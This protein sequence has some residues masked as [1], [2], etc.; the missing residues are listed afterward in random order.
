MWKVKYIDKAGKEHWHTYLF[1]DEI[2]L[3]GKIA[4]VEKANKWR[5]AVYFKNN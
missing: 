5:C 3:A 4:G 1:L 2:Q